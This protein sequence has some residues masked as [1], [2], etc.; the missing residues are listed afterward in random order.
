MPT[1]T[2]DSAAETEREWAAGVMARSEPW[3]VLGRGLEECLASCRDPEYRLYI[4]RLD[5]TPCGLI[6]LHHRGVAGS[7]YIA[8]VAVAEEHRS[9]GIGRCLL[10]FA[11][12]L[13][14]DSAAHMFLCVSSFNE[15]ARRFYERHGYSQVGEFKDYII[16]GA[17]EI[18]M[19]KRLRRE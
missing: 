14:V 7:P 18:L 1:L 2:I 3:M 17:S 16:N 12:N 9:S 5:E 11:E 15:R 6:L 4:A 8:A 19:H 13:F 10:E